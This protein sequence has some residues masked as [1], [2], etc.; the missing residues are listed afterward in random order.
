MQSLKDLIHDYKSGRLILQDDEFPDK[1]GLP[2]C[3]KCKTPRFYAF[4]DK[5]FATRCLCQ[6][7]QEEAEHQNRVREIEK[8]LEDFESHKQV[9]ES[10][11]REWWRNFRRKL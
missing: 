4:E 2:Y 3:C 1:D 11:L 5:S 10:T 6:C 9:T 7:Q 8:I